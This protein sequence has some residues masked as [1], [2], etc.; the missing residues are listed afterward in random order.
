MSILNTLG[1]PYP[2]FQAPM[3]GVATPTLAAAV[4]NAGGLGGLGLASVSPE[5]ALNMIRAT[6]RQT[7]QPFNVNVF[8]H[9]PPTLNRSHEQ[10]WL[11]YLTPLFKQFSQPVPTQLNDRYRTFLDDKDLLQVLLLTR[12]RV[13]SFHFGLPK[14]EQLELLHAAGIFTL[15]TATSIHEAQLIEQADIGGIVVQGIEAGGHRGIFNPNGPDEALSTFELLPK[16]KAQTALPLIATGGIMT[17]AHISQALKLGASAAQ[18]GTAFVAS[19]ESAANAI[20][21][22]YM[23]H[24]A[25][26]TTLTSTLSGRPARGIINDY[27]RYTH[28]PSAPTPPDYPLPYDSTKQ[29]Q[30]AVA[31]HGTADNQFDCGSY[32]AGTRVHEARHLPARQLMQLLVHELNAAND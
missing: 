13:V 17:G 8:C 6:Q 25:A 14:P 16:I 7:N 24:P 3:A 10:Q 21:R 5:Q 4:S 9:H 20:Y 1:I 31:D 29:L 19:P 2:I 18:L 11:N 32:W 28:R 12:P 15:A 22:A 30:Q 23:R 27:V 26:Q